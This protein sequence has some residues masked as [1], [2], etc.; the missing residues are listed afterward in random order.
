MKAAV[1]EWQ[2][3][4]APLF[5]VAG[6]VRVVEKSPAGNSGVEQRVSL[7][8]DCPHSKIAALESLGVSALVCG[9]ISRQVRECIE[10]RG[11]QVLPFVSGALDDVIDA[12]REDRLELTN[13][14][15]PG[16]GRCRRRQGRCNGRN[17]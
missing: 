17:K 16:C 8:T 15:M 4:I 1:T 7:P 3:R 10:A 13:Y 9:A 12:W 14:S 2:G 5:D 11:I 6:T